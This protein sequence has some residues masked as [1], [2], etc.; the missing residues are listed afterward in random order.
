MVIILHIEVYS[1]NNHYGSPGMTFISLP[2][3]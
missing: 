3:S 1:K 2:L